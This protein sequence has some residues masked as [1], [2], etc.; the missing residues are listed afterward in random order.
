MTRDRVYCPGCG[1]DYAI[2]PLANPPELFT[3]IYCALAFT[4]EGEIVMYLSEVMRA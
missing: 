3:C 2:Y 1:S 4:G